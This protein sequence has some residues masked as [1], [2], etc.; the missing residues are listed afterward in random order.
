MSFASSLVMG[1]SVGT[2]SIV[3][4]FLGKAADKIGIANTVYYSSISIIAIIILLS[5]YPLIAKK[6]ARQDSR[7]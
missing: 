7:H 6:A 5:F 3:M 2:A 4:I 1:L